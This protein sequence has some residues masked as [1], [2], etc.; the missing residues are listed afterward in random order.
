[1]K[2]QQRRC[3]A[4]MRG[5]LDASHGLLYDVVSMQH[6]KTPHR[7]GDRDAARIL[8]CL[9]IVWRENALVRLL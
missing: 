9:H 4:W 1:M 6:Q 5:Y 8:S 3:A 2:G 7:K